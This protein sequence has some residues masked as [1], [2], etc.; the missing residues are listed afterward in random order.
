MRRHWNILV[1]TLID[2]SISHDP[3]LEPDNQTGLEYIWL[4]RRLCEDWP[5]FDSDYNSNGSM[6]NNT[7]VYQDSSDRGCNIMDGVDSSGRFPN[8]TGPVLEILT[9]E[10]H[11]DDSVIIHLIVRSGGR[12]AEAIQEIYLT[13]EKVPVFTIA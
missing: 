4:C 2:G 8:A 13:Q 6:P 9:G 5:E 11:Q 3:D 12:E 10:M 7:C 1:P